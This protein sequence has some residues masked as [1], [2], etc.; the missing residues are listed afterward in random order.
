[1]GNLKLKLKG[2]LKSWTIW[3][4]SLAAVLV[5]MW[6]EIAAQL[7]TSLSPDQYRTFGLVMLIVNIGLRVKTNTALIDK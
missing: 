3:F 5:V 1:M 7:Q 2:A 6:P 4:N